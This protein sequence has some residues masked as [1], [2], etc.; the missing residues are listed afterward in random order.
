MTRPDDDFRA[1]DGQID[2]PA[3]QDAAVIGALLVAWAAAHGEKA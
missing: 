3:A 2:A 1:H